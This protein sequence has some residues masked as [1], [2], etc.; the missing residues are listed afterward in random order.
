M[1]AARSKPCATACRK[2]RPTTWCTAKAWVDRRT[3]M[4]GRSTGNLWAG[5]DGGDSWMT[6]S[7]HLPP[8]H[9]VRFG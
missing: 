9:A 8:I 6:V 4:F 7:T 2:G 1:A 5:N 3:L